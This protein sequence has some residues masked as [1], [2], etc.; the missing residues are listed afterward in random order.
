VNAAFIMTGWGIE[1]RWKECAPMDRTIITERDVR[2]IAL[3]RQLELLE[4]LPVSPLSESDEARATAAA[5]EVGAASRAERQLNSHERRLQEKTETRRKLEQARERGDTGRERQ[6]QEEQHTLEGTVSQSVSDIKSDYLELEGS[7]QQLFREYQ[8]LSRE[9]EDD[10][11]A[12]L[13]KY[14]PTEIVGAYLTL[15]GVILTAFE[16]PTRYAALWI[17]FGLIFLL[18]PW[19]LRRVQHVRKWKQIFVSM[20]AFVVW[21]FALGGAF[22][23]LSWYQPAWGTVALGLFSLAAVIISPDLSESP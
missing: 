9:P 3:R 16:G 20:G 18:T 22:V 11:F 13:L 1:V 12:K 17:I 6:L 23:S 15:Q 4:R 7:Y 21:V 8:Q 5:M 14:I 2:E 19:Y 10:R